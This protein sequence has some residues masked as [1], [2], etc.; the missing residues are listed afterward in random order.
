LDKTL[1][2]ITARGGS[3][4]IPGK[5]IR[6]LGGKPLI[7]YS[8]DLAKKFVPASNICVSTDSPEIAEVAE[9]RGLEVPFLRPHELATDTAGTYA[10]LQHAI[11]FYEEKV[12]FDRIILFQPTSPFRLMRHVRECVAE[13]EKG[14]DMATSVKNSKGNPYALLYVQNKE[15]Y[16][17]KVITGNDA[18]RRQDLP[19]V[20]QLNGAIYI[21]HKDVLMKSEPKNFSR[22][23]HYEMPEENSV[24]IDEP[25]DWQWAEFLLEK[26]IV[27]LDYE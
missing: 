10:V 23:R 27:Q 15:G 18:T 8:I 2:V 11:T 16:I 21:Y 6:I 4:G 3:K 17:E 14:C 22:I 26:K 7:W 12:E 25:I 1:F 24:D 19:K 20:Y 9:R 13:F 5:N